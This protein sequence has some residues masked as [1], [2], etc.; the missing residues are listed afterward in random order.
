MKR[1][2]TGLLAA[3]L[4]GGAS[5]KAASVAKTLDIY[6]IDVEGGQATLMVTPSGESFLVDGGFPGDGTFNSTPG[7][8]AVARDA[9]RVLAAAR[10]AG[11]KQIDHLLITHF[12]ADHF[13]AVMELSQLLPIKEFIDHAAPSAAADSAVPGT[14]ALY[15]AYAAVRSTG[16][17]RQPKAGDQLRFKD[18]TLD[19]LASDGQVRSTSVSGAGAPNTACASGGVPAQ[20][21]LENPLSTAVRFTYGQFRFLDVGDLSGA[22]LHALTCP[23][24]LIG[25]SELYLIA[26][27]GGADGADPALF[28]A[29]K[30]LVAVFNNGPRK[31]AQPPTFATLRQMPAIDAWQLHRTTYPTAENLPDARIVNL[32]LSTNAWL[33][34]SAQADGAFTVTNGRTGEAKSYR[35]TASH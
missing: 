28:T 9:Q 35:R 24:N 13:G 7:D 32:D 14:M 25:E 29:V 6:F 34:V 21:K 31:G 26:H 8:P 2:L 4:L 22:P 11:I 5:L 33:K 15:R 16:T 19:V 17:H 18:V 10:D 12:H 3:A 27:H 1:L 30:P 23:V 20:E